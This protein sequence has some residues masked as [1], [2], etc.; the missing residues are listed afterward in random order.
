[1]KDGCERCERLIA[2]LRAEFEQLR[3]PRKELMR[4]VKEIVEAIIEDVVAK[5]SALLT[6]IEQRTLGLLADVDRSVQ[7]MFDTLSDRLR[8]PP[9]LH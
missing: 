6:K 8:L 5:N 3:E 4:E 9:R 2:D 7:R 1:M